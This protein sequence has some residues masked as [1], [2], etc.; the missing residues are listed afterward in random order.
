MVGQFSRYSLQELKELQGQLRD[1]KF[2]LDTQKKVDA[3]PDKQV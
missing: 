3:S 2:Y 1:V